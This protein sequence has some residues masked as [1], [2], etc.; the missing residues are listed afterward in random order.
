M[1]GIEK[2]TAR[3]EADGKAAVEEILRQ[4]GERAG[5][6][7]A[8]Y[9]RQAETEA[10]QARRSGAEA[11]QRQL[12]RLE[13]AA[14]MEAR[15]ELLSAKQACLDETFDAALRRLAELP[16]ADYAALLARMAAREARTGREEIILNPRD[17]D[18]VGLQVAAQA[19]AL[20]AENA[21]PQLARDLAG[22]SRTG[23]ILSKV[24]AGASAVLQGTALLT[25]SQETRDLT[26]GL[27]LKDGNV[28]INC[29]F[30]AQLRSL[31][32]SMAAEIAG[33]LF[34]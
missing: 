7:R 15:K 9:G 23:N 28:E 1:N 6:V 26:G 11:A 32:E 18:R 16:E 33:I 8:E 27:I 21:A 12:E 31:R 34:A 10:D 24:V 25:L 29:S 14:R 13:S 2:I 3:I 22:G 20:L 19:N 5:A 4:A 17:R 30:E